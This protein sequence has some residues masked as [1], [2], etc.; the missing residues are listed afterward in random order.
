M[1]IKETIERFIKTYERPEISPAT[2]QGY[3]IDCQTFLRWIEQYGK[4][5][6]EEV[7]RQDIRSYLHYMETERKY[8][9]KTIKRKL[10]VVKLMFDYALDYDIIE[11]TP[12]E[13]RIKINVKRD[14][15]PEAL[16]LSEVNKLL[17]TVHN[18][19]TRYTEFTHLRDIAI[20]ELLF[21]TGIRVA[22][23]ANLKYC[24]WDNIERCFQFTAKSNKDRTVFVDNREV[25]TAFYDYITLASTYNAEYIFINKT[26]DQISTSAIRDVL[27][28]YSAKICT[29]KRITPHMLRRSYATLLLENG[30]D[31]ANVQKALGHSS[32]GT[33]QY[34]LKISEQAQRRALRANN[35]RDYMSFN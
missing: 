9:Q 8:K 32:I 11:H 33:T 31:I 27:K 23:L 28:K 5:K 19:P 4:S 13:R 29:N 26:H 25:L 24:D 35:P 18:L 16:E 20:V 3:T 1:E 17:Y 22:E 6:I 34:Y 15:F 10:L 21:Y 2:V 30:T 7:S 12:F 14:S